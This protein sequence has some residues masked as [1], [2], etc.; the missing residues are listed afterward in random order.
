MRTSSF[1][2]SPWTHSLLLSQHPLQ[3]AAEPA[4][5]LANALLSGLAQETS[6]RMVPAPLSAWHGFES[7]MF[8][9]AEPQTAWEPTRTPNL[10]K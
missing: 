7:H 5:V 1:I 3:E 10:E 4:S 2:S 9:M 8:T 6:H